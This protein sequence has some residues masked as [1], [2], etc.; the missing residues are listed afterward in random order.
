MAKKGAMPTFEMID[1]YIAYQKK[2]VQHK[3]KEMRALIFEAAPQAHE[4]RNT[5]VPT[6]TLVP[7]EKKGRFS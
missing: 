4:H 5:K 3:L 2:E 6:Y 7:R 1:D